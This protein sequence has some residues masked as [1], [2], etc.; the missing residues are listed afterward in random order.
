MRCPEKSLCCDITVGQLY[1][2]CWP[3]CRIMLRT[4]SQVPTPEMRAELRGVCHFT[5]WPIY[6]QQCLLTPSRDV[7]HVSIVQQRKHLRQALLNNLYLPRKH[8][9][10]LGISQYGMSLWTVTHRHHARVRPF[11]QPQPPIPSITKTSHRLP[12]HSPIPLSFPLQPLFIGPSHRQPYPVTS[13]LAPPLHSLHRKPPS[14][15]RITKS[16]CSFVA[17]YGI[18]ARPIAA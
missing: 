12:L 10:V 7:T 3:A 4:A 16:T 11:G 17:A 6:R 1:G 18:I 13:H 15:S 2:G 14:L 9:S 8:R 5:S